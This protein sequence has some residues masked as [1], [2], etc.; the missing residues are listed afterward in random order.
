MKA[1]ATLILSCLSIYLIGQDTT[2]YTKDWNKAESVFSASFYEVIQKSQDD[3][4]RA[5]ALLYFKS[6]QIKRSKNYANFKEKKLDGIYQEWFD[7]GNLKEDIEYSNG[8]FNGF[9]KTYWE[10]GQ[11]K[12]L[13]SFKNGEFIR[14]ECFNGDGEVISYYAYEVMPEFKGG[15]DALMKYLSEEIKYPKKARRKNIQGLVIV[16]F[17]VNTDGSIYNIKIV[18][19]I[20]EEL[21]KEAIRVVSGMPN[22]NAGRQDGEAIK[23]SFNLPVRYR[24][25]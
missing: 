11:K 7:N 5:S 2:F 20:N 1:S 15:M 12:R 6:G 3:T 18:K 17:V 14:G 13:D 16:G 9:L 23:V 10:N 8:K 24:L 21:D 19:S 22:W 25:K 4:M